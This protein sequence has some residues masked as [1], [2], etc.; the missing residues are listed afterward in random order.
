MGALRQGIDSIFEGPVHIPLPLKT[1]D[2]INTC[3]GS[4]LAHSALEVGGILKSVAHEITCP[5][6]WEALK[7]VPDAYATR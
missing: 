5:L 6:G 4:C 7:H 1:C 3:H 2:W